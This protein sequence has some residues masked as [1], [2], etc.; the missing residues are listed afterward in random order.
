MGFRVPGLGSDAV[1][2]RGVLEIRGAIELART[3]MA[4]IPRRWRKT[5]LS[6]FSQEKCGPLRVRAE[7]PRRS[8]PAR[9]VR[10]W[11][12]DCRPRLPSRAR[13]GRPPHPAR[14]SRRS[15]GVRQRDLALR[16]RP[17]RPPSETIARRRPRPFLHRR[18]ARRGKRRCAPRWDRR[19]FA[20]RKNQR[21]D[22]LRLA[23][24]PAPVAH[25]R[26]VMN[27]ARR[28]PSSAALRYQT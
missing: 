19:S 25:S 17:F 18:R 22:S 2:A 11:L 20:D 3:H 7:R 10:P 6:R 5:C 23:T 1:P 15:K 26:P 8:G 21:A 9:R 14:R 12:R 28:S 24:T 13:R 27:W 16:R 4:K